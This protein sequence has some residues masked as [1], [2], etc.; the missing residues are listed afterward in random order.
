MTAN[1][2]NKEKENARKA[3]IR[4]V[5]CQLVNVSALWRVRRGV[6]A[7]QIVPVII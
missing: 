7:T 2:H 6:L 3:T 1:T 5:Q 4:F